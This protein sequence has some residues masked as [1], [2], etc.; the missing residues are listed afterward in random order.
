M[1]AALVRIWDALVEEIQGWRD[2][3]TSPE[4]F[5]AI[6]LR[7]ILVAFGA[8]VGIVATTEGH[9]ILGLYGAVSVTLAGSLIYLRLTGKP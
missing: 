2:A 4:I 1:L 8:V 6:L 7:V 3:L 9:E 5:L